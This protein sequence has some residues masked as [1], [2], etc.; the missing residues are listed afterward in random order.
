MPTKKIIFLAIIVGVFA[1]S[2]ATYLFFSKS[3]TEKKITPAGKCGDGVCNN[4][5]KQ[6]NLCPLDCASNL[7]T[8]EIPYYFIAIHNEPHHDSEDRTNMSIEENYVTLEKIIKKADEYN[9]KLT[10]MFTAQWSDYIF[11][12]S[13]KIYKLDLWKKSGHE[14]AA[15]HHSETHGN[16]DGY[17]NMPYEEV[18][19]LRTTLGRSTSE[20]YLGTMDDYTEK[21]L[22]LN[23]EVKSGCMND[24]TDKESMPSEIIYST[25][26]GKPTNTAIKSPYRDIDPLKG[27]NDFMVSYFLQETKLYGISHSQ[28]NNENLL[29]EA[30][31]AF[32]SMQIGVYGAVAHSIEKNY[33]TGNLYESETII[34]FMEFLHSVDPTGE[35]SR[36][37]S[38]VIEQKLL[39]EKAI[40]SDDLL[41][42]QPPTPRTK[43]STSLCGD[44]VCNN[45]EKQNNVCP[46]DCE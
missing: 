39:S 32:S 41:N 7:T 17:S 28:V 4:I 27:K 20:S 11:S 5:E 38:E 15:H 18:I 16:W 34:K 22:K 45:I 12:D 43:T 42:S 30:K 46:Q 40:S 36:T 3:G 19:K 14:I 44:G 33:M 6:N 13:E 10:L 29:I 2:L 23:P 8:K 25:C 21:I 9:I 35:K 37:V 1:L 31:N 24:E 26:T